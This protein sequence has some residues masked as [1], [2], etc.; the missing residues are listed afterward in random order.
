MG[1]GVDHVREEGA[2][3][4]LIEDGPRSDLFS[5]G[6]A[7]KESRTYEVQRGTFGT[8]AAVI[9]GVYSEME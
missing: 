1:L 2:E 6:A 8:E 7:Q 9:W 4:E 3:V 5:G